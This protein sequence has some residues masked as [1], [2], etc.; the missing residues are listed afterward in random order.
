MLP[1]HAIL[2]IGPGIRFM[3]ARSQVQDIDVLLALD[4]RWVSAA[5]GATSK[6]A[7][8]TDGTIDRSILSIALPFMS[9]MH[10]QAGP[11]DLAGR[12]VRRAHPTQQFRVHS[13]P[14]WTD[15]RCTGTFRPAAALSTAPRQRAPC[16]QS[17]LELIFRC[18]SQRGEL[19]L[20]AQADIGLLG[21]GLERSEP[22]DLSA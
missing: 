5:S 15:A 3:H 10:M 8:K 11:R 1:D 16:V 19:L 21:C 12:V 14:A 18:R 6:A 13:R 17:K 2:S 9:R 7:A 4:F 20:S 22:A